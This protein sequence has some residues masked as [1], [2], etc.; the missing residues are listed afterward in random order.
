MIAFLV[1]R[2]IEH[3][4]YLVKVSCRYK[5]SKND[6]LWL[7]FESKQFE[8]GVGVVDEGVDDPLPDLFAFDGGVAADLGAS[9]S[10]GEFASPFCRLTFA[11]LFESDRIVPDPEL[12]DIQ[13]EPE[14]SLLGSSACSSLTPG[15][16]FDLFEV[17][18]I[19]FDRGNRVFELVHAFAVRNKFEPSVCTVPE[20]LQSCFVR[21][22]KVFL[23]FEEQLSVRNRLDE[24]Q[25]IFSRVSHRE[26]FLKVLNFG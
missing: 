21:F 12:A 10:F 9:T 11:V 14:G 13:G 6:Q 4:F 2:D 22:T 23:V 20:L 19:L 26:Q 25:R 16:F 8:K 5:M 7:I 18:G 17:L 24:G 15:H 3:K 1:F